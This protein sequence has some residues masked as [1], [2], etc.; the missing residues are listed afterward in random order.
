MYIQVFHISGAFDEEVVYL[1]ENSVNNS[2]HSPVNLPP[3][4]LK[5]ASGDPVIITFLI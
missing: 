5:T 1:E 2:G 4:R 3:G